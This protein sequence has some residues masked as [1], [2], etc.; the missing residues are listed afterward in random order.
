MEDSMTN[1]EKALLK[2]SEDYLKN[3]IDEIKNMPTKKKIILGFA[4]TIGLA[5]VKDA[6]SSKK[7]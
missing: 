7:K 5:V 3:K 1:V 6:L 2:K 4:T